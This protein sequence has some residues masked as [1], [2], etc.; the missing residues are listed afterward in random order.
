L[1]LFGLNVIVD[2]SGLAGVKNLTNDTG[3]FWD[4]NLAAID[5]SRGFADQ[6]ITR[7]VR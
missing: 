7:A 6:L 5:S 1:L 2:T 3:V 4:L